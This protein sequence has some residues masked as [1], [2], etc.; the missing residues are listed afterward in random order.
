[1]YDNM[2]DIPYPLEE[3]A[4]N[5]AWTGFN[6]T[7]NLPKYLKGYIGLYLECWITQMFFSPFILSSLWLMHFQVWLG[8]HQINK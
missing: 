4:D 5:A 6:K 2:T 8:T 7:D 1:M 3:P